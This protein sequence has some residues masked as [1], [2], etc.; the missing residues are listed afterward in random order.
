MPTVRY[1]QR[2]VDT[3]PLPGVRKTAA[4]T[5]LSEG[6]G[7]EQARAQTAETVANLGGTAARI[8][9]QAFD[10]YQQQERQ[11]ADQIAVLNASNQLAD[12]ETQRLYDPDSGAL[13]VKGK[14]AF[15]LPEK[16]RADFDQRADAIEQGLAT[17]TQRQAFQRLKADRWQSIDLT[18]R[19]HVFGEMDAYDQAEVANGVNNSIDLAIKNATD[20]RR[21]GVELNGAIDTLKSAAAR[22]GVGPETLEAQIAD[23]KTKVHAGV[24]DRLLENDNPAAARIYFDETKDQIA[25]DKVGAIEKAIA[26]GGL[27]KSAQQKA[28][29]IV[30]GGGS[31]TEQRE[32]ARA[33]DDPDLRDAVMQR[34]EHEDAVRDKAQRDADE[35]QLRG[36]Y[37]IVDRTHD[38]ASIPPATWSQLDGST[39]SALRGYAENLVRG[40]PTQTDPTT[41]YS[42]MRQ[43]ADDPATFS[44]RNLLELRSKLDDG[45]FKQLANLQLS[46]RQGDNRKAASDL[47]GF[48]TNSQIV[49]DALELNGFETRPKTDTAA[50]KKQ[51]ADVAQ[52][53]RIVDQQV[54]SLQQS[55]GRKATND[56]VR[57]IVDEAIKTF[58]RPAVDPWGP[59][60]YKPARLFEV[61][62]GDIP[63]QDRADIE[64]AL[65]RRGRPVTDATIISL[66]LANQQQGKK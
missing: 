55:T 65:R 44:R 8:G 2:K 28:D 32:K 1:G 21:V 20:V 6:A 31:L 19:R 7:L 17:D 23:V 49:D 37:D 9:V 29:E 36:V 56:D 3:A 58:S 38:V 14:D 26:E 33:I 4:E 24:I 41:Y 47:S 60:G 34:I 50:G 51:A 11:R 46:Y 48:R 30:A 16:V 5:P 40:V 39:R 52:L 66:Y 61:T 62:V 35:A 18:V 54:E 53:Y 25:G 12:F 15:D 59:F 57:G 64:A 63:P 45:D 10:A 43:A 13:T 27:R 42:L 22:R